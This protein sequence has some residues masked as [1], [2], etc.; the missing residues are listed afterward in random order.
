EIP[1]AL[2]VSLAADGTR[3]CGVWLV[4]GDRLEIIGADTVA[5][6]Y[7]PRSL[8][9]PLDGDSALARA[10]RERRPFYLS[11]DQA[12]QYWNRGGIRGL[13]PGDRIGVV[14][15]TLRDH[16]F[17]AVVLIDLGEDEFDTEERNFLAAMGHEIAQGI[18]RANL[19]AQQASLA[20]VSAFLAEAA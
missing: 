8:A 10:V 20:K 13:P 6:G 7:D 3:W 4:R 14:P 1:A 2:A 19:Y 12:P 18:D 17:G 5:P 15:L 16:C 11:S 9:W